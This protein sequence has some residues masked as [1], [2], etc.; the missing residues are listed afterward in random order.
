M[1]DYVFIS[2][3]EAFMHAVLSKA[4]THVPLWEISWYNWIS[5]VIGEVSR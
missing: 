5:G 4:E 1:T 3:V 2:E